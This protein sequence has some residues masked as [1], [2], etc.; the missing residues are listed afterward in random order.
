MI[1]ELNTNWHRTL[2]SYAKHHMKKEKEELPLVWF[3]ESTKTRF[4]TKLQILRGELVTYF[5][6]GSVRR[7]EPSPTR[8]DQKRPK[9]FALIPCTRRRRGET[10]RPRPLLPLELLRRPQSADGRF[11]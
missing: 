6:P 9:P 3:R 7:K 5:A 1:I 11:H 4:S 2:S 8:F 10:S